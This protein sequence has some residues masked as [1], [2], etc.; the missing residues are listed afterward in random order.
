MDTGILTELPLRLEFTV[1]APDAPD[2][3]D[4]AGIAAMRRTDAHAE[5]ARWLA[6]DRRPYNHDRPAARA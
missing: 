4:A 5:F 2:A 6:G 3:P 1:D